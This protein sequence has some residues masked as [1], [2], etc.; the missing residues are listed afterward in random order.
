MNNVFTQDTQE[1]VD[2]LYGDEGTFTPEE[3]KPSSTQFCSKKGWYHCIVQGVKPKNLYQDKYPSV[4]RVDLQI[5]AGTEADQ[6]DCMIFHDIRLFR[7]KYEMET[8][9]QTGKQRRK[10]ID[11]KPIET[12]A[13]PYGHDYAAQAMKAARAMGLVKAGEAAKLSQ[14]NWNAADQTQVI[15]RVDE[16][17]ERYTDRDGLPQSIKKY[18][19]NFGHFWS[20]L[21]RDRDDCPDEVKNCPMDGE[22]LA[23]LTGGAGIG[24]GADL[25]GI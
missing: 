12:G 4:I 3:Q 22:M 23:Y 20:P 2:S 18:N 5:L 25:D 1:F 11:G 9:P 7:I 24:A 15:V 16:D 17:E 8:D 10:Q 13:E 19:I 6:K 21:D 14:V